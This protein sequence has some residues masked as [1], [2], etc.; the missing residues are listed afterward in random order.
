M[1]GQIN[2]K[3]NYKNDEY[4]ISG[5]SIGYLFRPADFGLQPYSTMTACWNGYQVCYNI[6]DNHLVVETMLINLKD[7]EKIING[8]KP[9]KLGKPDFN[10][11]GFEANHNFFKLL[12]KD[13]NLKIPFSGGLLITKDFIEEMYV[14][15][16]FQNPMSYRIVYE[17]TFENGEL[18]KFTDISEVMEKRRNEGKNHDALPRSDEKDAVGKWIERKFSLEYETNE[19]NK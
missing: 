19:E 5:V 13:L 16:G 12:Y 2:D 18:V 9:I 14:H 8:K 6:V 15:M 7:E 10:A 1:T 11:T 17:L 4:Y 3:F